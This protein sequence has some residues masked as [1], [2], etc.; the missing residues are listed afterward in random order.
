M[1]AAHTDVSNL[2]FKSGAAG[3]GRR[4]FFVGTES[5]WRGCRSARFPPPE[6]EKQARHC[7]RGGGLFVAFW[8][9]RRCDQR[10]SSSASCWW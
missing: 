8:G 7:P 4:S 5:R 6:H 3:Y 1:T 2:P 10:R 9:G